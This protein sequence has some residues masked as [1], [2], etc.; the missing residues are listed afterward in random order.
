MGCWEGVRSV[1]E[2]ASCE[3]RGA[4]AIHP[5]M[6]GSAARSPPPRSAGAAPR[7]P[8]NTH[9]HRPAGPLRAAL[10]LPLLRSFVLIFFSSSS[11]PIFWAL[12][13]WPARPAG[14]LRGR[15]AWGH[16]AGAA[17]ASGLLP[18]PLSPALSRS[19]GPRCRLQQP[20][21]GGAAR[22][23][24][25]GGRTG[26]GGARLRWG[27]EGK[28][29]AQ[30]RSSVVPFTLGSGHAVSCRGHAGCAGVALA[31]FWPP[32]TCGKGFLLLERL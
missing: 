25:G 17:A 28:P 3:G 22:R 2:A 13:L 4:E 8:W 20:F 11:P 14:C 5:S 23:G 7:P 19:P 1:S 16:A 9:P 18:P 26:S 27:A 10:L 12:P 6:I 15:A 29:P 24:P 31:R 32:L 30:G 21:L